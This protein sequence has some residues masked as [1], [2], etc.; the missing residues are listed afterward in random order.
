[1]KNTARPALFQFHKGTIKTCRF[2][3]SFRR[4]QQFQ[5]HKGTIKTYYDSTTTYNNI[6]F[7]S[8]KVRLKHQLIFDKQL[9]KLFQFH[10]GTIKTCHC[11]SF[12]VY[13]RI[14]IP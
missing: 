14:S 1:M 6:N 11:A 9:I 3:A 12:Q 5:F 2:R 13:H 10:K 8:I 4:L 7:N